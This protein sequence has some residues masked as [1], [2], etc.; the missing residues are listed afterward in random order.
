MDEVPTP[1]LVLGPP[2]PLDR[3]VIED[4]ATD[5]EIVDG[6][7]LAAGEP[8]PMLLLLLAP[9]EEAPIF[10]AGEGPMSPA[11]EGT[12]LVVR[13][14]DIVITLAVDEGSKG[15][16]AGGPE[17][18]FVVALGNLT[19]DDASIDDSP[20]VA[21]RLRMITGNP[22]VLLRPGQPPEPVV[23]VLPPRWLAGMEV[24]RLLSVMVIVPFAGRE[25]WVELVGIVRSEVGIEPGAVKLED[26]RVALV[27]ATDVGR[28]PLIRAREVEFGL[29]KRVGKLVGLVE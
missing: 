12:I 28:V 14:V 17:P 10:D 21:N 5:E 29:N 25:V 9:T 18:V 6:T 22:V 7:P 15:V 20:L 16:V 2:P 4:E 3:G 1:W 26:G 23:V 19:V 11:L 24:G 13:P 8:V 27:T